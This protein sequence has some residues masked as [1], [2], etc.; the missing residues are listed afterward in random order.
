MLVDARQGRREQEAIAL[1]LPWPVTGQAGRRE[2]TPQVG[3]ARGLGG[4]AARKHTLLE[5]AQH[6]RAHG[7]EP[8][9][10]DADDAHAAPRQPVAQAHLHGIQCRQHVV[11]VG[12]RH[13]L[14]K[15]VRGRGGCRERAACRHARACLG[16]DGNA[17]VGA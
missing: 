8:G 5:P 3:R 16:Q 10:A 13:C 1:L 12:L 14:G 6:Q 7:R 4:L 17:A 2:R 9:Q 11:A 15:L